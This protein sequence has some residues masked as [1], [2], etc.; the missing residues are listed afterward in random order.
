[1]QKGFS[2]RLTKGAGTHLASWLQEVTA[3]TAE[4]GQTLL[5][6]NGSQP[7]STI[8]GERAKEGLLKSHGKKFGHSKRVTDI[9]YSGDII[10]T[11][12]SG[13]M[14][15]WR[16]RGDFALL[17]VVSCRGKHVTIHPCGQYIVTGNRS[18][19]NSNKEESKGSKKTIIKIWGPA[20]QSAVGI[21]NA[22][23]TRG[24]A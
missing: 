8:R 23:I 2:G 20:G 13:Q 4:E 21:G 3:L 18:F 15:L 22:K 17:R 5:D 12:D 11:K 7:S 24:K 19:E 1:M 14:R 10:I 6:E 16:A 9:A